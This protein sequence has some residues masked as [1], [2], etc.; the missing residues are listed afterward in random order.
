[1]DFA[2]QCTFPVMSI[3]ELLLMSAGRSARSASRPAPRPGL[4]EYDSILGSLNNIEC[5]F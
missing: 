1:M 2:F 5:I 4:N 3:I